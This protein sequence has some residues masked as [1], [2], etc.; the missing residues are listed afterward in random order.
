MDRL[1]DDA[2]VVNLS[3]RAHFRAQMDFVNNMPPKKE[4][5]VPLVNY[6]ISKCCNILYSRHLQ[7]VF[8]KEN[9]KR[10]TY[11]VH[12]GLIPSTE[13]FRTVTEFDPHSLPNAKT[14]PQGAAT[15][16]LCALHSSVLEHAGEYFAD[17]G[18]TQEI[19]DDAKN[20]E[21]AAKLWEI[22]EELV[23]PF[24]NL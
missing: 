16:L 13:L 10:T 6:G 19:T 5:Y 12:P 2:R 1:A 8:N 24:S 15:T 20:E 4:L 23:K 7:K 18:L 17:C 21:Y 9:S 14:V 3:S 11:S 22:S